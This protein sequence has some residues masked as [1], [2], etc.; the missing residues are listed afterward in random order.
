[1]RAFAMLATYRRNQALLLEAPT[2]SENGPPQL[3]TARATIARVLGDG[4]D[5]LNELEA[6]ALL[7]AYGIPVVATLE[8]E[9]VAGCRGA[10]RDAARLSGRA[11]DRLARH[12]PQVRRRRRR[13][14]LRDE[15]SVRLA[16]D[17]M[18]AAV[19]AARP[20]RG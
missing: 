12:Q 17:Q 20:E 13:L 2:A 16:A 11:Q 1:V 15:A 10:R 9:A 18:L 8:V 14:D 7:R 3:E 4:R 19:H 5:M 6:K